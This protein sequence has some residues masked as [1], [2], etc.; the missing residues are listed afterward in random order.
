MLDNDVWKYNIYK[1]QMDPIFL[2]FLPFSLL[3]A[4]L[5]GDSVYEQKG[6]M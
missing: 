3:A 6:L 2:R 1:L 4:L 5:F